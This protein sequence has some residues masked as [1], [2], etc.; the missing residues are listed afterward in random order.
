MQAS[1]RWH[2]KPVSTAR[3]NCHRTASSLH[4]V[5]IKSGTT[6]QSR[7]CAPMRT[8][9]EERGYAVVAGSAVVTSC[10]G[11]V[12]DVLAAVITRPPVDADAVVAAVSIV[13]CSSILACVRH[14]LTLVH[15]FRAVLT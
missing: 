10:T 9:A 2:S 15:I 7:T 8:L 4:R 14:Q 3:T 11:T 1:S 13:A 12:V 6:R 5:G